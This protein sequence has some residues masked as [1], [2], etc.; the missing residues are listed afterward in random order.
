M[1]V[2]IFEDS[3]WP[4]FAPLALSRPVFMLSCGMG[5]LLER[6]IE[7]LKP[8][9]LTLWVRPQ[10]AELCRRHVVPGL[11]IPTTVNE[12]L[13]DQHAMLVSAGVVNA[14]VDIPAGHLVNAENAQ[15]IQFA[16]I[17][18]K[19]GLSHDDALNHTD[20]WLSLLN[21]P[22]AS[23]SF[24]VA[25]YLWHLVG[26][27]QEMLI[28]DF[29]RWKDRPNHWKDG[30]YHLID[31][32]HIRLGQ[33]AKLSPGCVLDASKGP[34]VV[35]EGASIGANAVVQGPCYIGKHSTIHPLALIRPGTSI[36]M[37]CKLGGEVSNSIVCDYTNKA[38]DGFLGD[39]YLGS[40]VNL[41]A[42]TTTS[43][44]KNTYGEV[45]MRIGAREYKT[46]R[47]MLGSLIGDHTK[48]AIGTRL[49]TGTYVGYNCLLAG[50]G[51]S[52]TFIPSFTFWTADRTERYD[53]KKASEVAD[54]VMHRREKAWTDL[55]QS[56]QQYVA[57]AA[58]KIEG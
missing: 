13:D 23:H 41:G 20:A 1:H 5:T 25:E 53:L 12:P 16:H 44:L 46:G 21:L 9:R 4:G 17:E 42:G 37:H 52:P 36:G 26:A 34:I 2:V 54:K 56:I 3:F 7:M 51:L 32:E 31:A 14:T 27:S 39:S 47:T 19:P 35:D 24:P 28:A 49:N 30:P 22:R 33:G 10:M 29:P 40:W 50:N 11:Q 43:N 58:P 48:T 45:T 38:H 8:T 55:D 6:Q 57:D 15:R 18:R